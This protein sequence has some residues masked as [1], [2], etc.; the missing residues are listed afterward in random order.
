MARW[1][2]R[3]DAL[4]ARDRRRRAW[5][6]RRPPASSLPKRQQRAMNQP[7]SSSRS[8]Q[9]A[10]SQS[11]TAGQPAV[12]DHVVAGAEVA[13]H[14]ARP[15]GSGACAI[16]PG[17]DV[18]ER[19]PRLGCA[20]RA[21]RGTW[22]P[23]REPAARIGIGSAGQ[24]GRAAAGWRGCGPAPRRAVSASLSPKFAERRIAHELAALRRAADAALDQERPADHARSAQRAI[25]SATATPAACGR[26]QHART[27]PPGRG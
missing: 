22:P 1:L 12:V 13:V 19:R 24:R 5:R 2:G 27:R 16:E 18:L 23:R 10:N 11:S 21:R 4:V 25:G 17:E 7:M 14:Q 15:A 3:G 9:W 8:P 6:C 26:L 20:C